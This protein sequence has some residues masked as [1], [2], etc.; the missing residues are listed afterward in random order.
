M[1][2]SVDRHVARWRD[3]G[4]ISFNDEVEGAVTR[5]SMIAKHLKRTSK[6]AAEEVGMQWFEYE[7]LHALMIRETPGSATPTELADRLMVSPAGIT[8]RLDGMERG[9][10]LRRV[11]DA[12]DR[13]RVD[14]EITEK[15]RAQW[16]RVMNLNGEAEISMIEVLSATEQRTLNRLLRK[17]LLPLDM[18]PPT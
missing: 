7:T 6:Q 16:K 1:E 14:V 9:G 8:G 3:W 17:V 15:G 10:L 18:P 2:D 4:E 11:R 5:I 13:R 12:G